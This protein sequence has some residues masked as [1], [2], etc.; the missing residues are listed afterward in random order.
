MVND[1]LFFP[2]QLILHPQYEIARRIGVNFYS[3][4]FACEKLLMPSAK[5]GA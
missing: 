1:P 4:R 2:C 5:T 3:C